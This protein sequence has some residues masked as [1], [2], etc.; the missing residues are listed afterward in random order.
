MLIFPLGC[1]FD[2]FFPYIFLLWLLVTFHF[3][4]F[5]FP[6]AP[7]AVMSWRITIVSDMSARGLKTRVLI[8]EFLLC[9]ITKFFGAIS[10]LS[11]ERLFTMCACLC[12]L[13]HKNGY[14]IVT[15]ALGYNCIFLIATKRFHILMGSKITLEKVSEKQPG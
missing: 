9:T 7:W 4:R 5:V 1:L 11:S 13:R 12:K 3:V 8:T 10:P 6:D 15:V 2:F 14:S